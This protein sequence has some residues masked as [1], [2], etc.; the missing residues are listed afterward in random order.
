M[1]V[2]AIYDRP[3]FNARRRASRWKAYAT[4]VLGGVVLAGVLWWVKQRAEIP[5]FPI[6]TVRVEGEFKHLARTQVHAALAQHARGGF[7]SVDV[8]VVRRAAESVPWVAT[9]SVWRVWPDTLNVSIT[10]QKPVARWGEE[11]LLNESAQLFRPEPQSIPS[12][13]P[14]L[15][16]PPGSAPALV[17]ELRELNAQLL[18]LRQSVLRLELD[19]RRAWRAELSNG[20]VLMLGRGGVGERVE[21]YTRAFPEWLASRVRDIERID[22]RYTNGF[23]VR[24]RDSG[25]NEVARKLR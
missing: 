18:P 11:G 16:G 15:Y 3:L 14:V 21:R 24:W 10:E 6:N 12:G 17:N 7:F 9:V 22:V 1:A 13:L 20:I 4:W 23:A 25:I 2:D 5:W 8:D 19:A